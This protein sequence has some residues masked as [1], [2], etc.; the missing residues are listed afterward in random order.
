MTRLEA[1]LSANGLVA[2][3]LV[4]MV[5]GDLSLVVAGVL[6]HLGLLPLVGAILA[7]SAGN[8]A[9][10][11]AWFA[12]GRRFR[13]RIRQTRLYRAVGPR[14]ERLAA[15]LGPWQLLAA[16]VVWGTRN[17]SMVFWGQHG[18]RLARFLVIDAIGCL[19]AA[20]G[21]V[22][23]GFGLGRGTEALVGEVK[24]AEHW[25][26]LGLLAGAVLV[27]GISHLVRRELGD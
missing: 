13:E 24:R 1:F 14:I 5:E 2:V 9:G 6:V 12:A 17:A 21:F 11:L 22:L 19:L 20:T 7:G 18:V 26:A 25:L 16:R 8:L 23:L 15:R 3:L 27:Y 4:A 10:D